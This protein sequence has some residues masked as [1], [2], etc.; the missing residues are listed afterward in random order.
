MQK[1]KQLDLKWRIPS[2]PASARGPDVKVSDV[3]TWI[4]LLV[5]FLVFILVVLL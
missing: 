1:R 4:T 2:A 5:M 3:K